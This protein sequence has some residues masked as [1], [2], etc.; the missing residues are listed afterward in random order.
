[1]QLESFILGIEGLLV[2]DLQ[3]ALCCVLEQDTLSSSKED[4]EQA[5]K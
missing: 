3:K 2:R 5:E 4:R 1:M